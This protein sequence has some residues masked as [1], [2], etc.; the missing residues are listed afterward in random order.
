MD[1]MICT[2]K[3]NFSDTCFGKSLKAYNQVSTRLDLL[4]NIS[5][6]TFSV[7][8]IIWKRIQYYLFTILCTFSHHICRPPISITNAK[9]KILQLHPFPRNKLLRK[10]LD[11]SSWWTS[12]KE[13]CTRTNI[14]LRKLLNI[15]QWWTGSNL[16]WSGTRKLSIQSNTHF[17][18][19]AFDV[20]T[21]HIP[22]K[23]SLRI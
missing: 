13:K 14:L 7:E 3:E 22:I 10:W 1:Y 6:F 19:C 23:V 4:H 16:R 8:W 12:S 17:F 20:K 15:A 18:I 9:S 21:V 2:V 11:T 5:K